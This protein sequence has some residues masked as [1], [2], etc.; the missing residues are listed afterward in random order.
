MH[1][2]FSVSWIGTCSS[3]LFGRLQIPQRSKHKLFRENNLGKLRKNMK[4][5]RSLWWWL[6]STDLIWFLSTSTNLCCVVIE[7]A[8]ES[9]LDARGT[10]TMRFSGLCSG[11]TREEFL[12]Y[13][14]LMAYGR[15]VGISGL[16]S[17]LWSVKIGVFVLQGQCLHFLLNLHPLRSK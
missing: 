11:V 13:F 9:L 3:K 8:A 6:A 4:S 16:Q 2:R 7:R 5:L 1:N 14:W 15:W 10:L 17:C 12:W